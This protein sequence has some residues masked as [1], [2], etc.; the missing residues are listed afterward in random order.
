MRGILGRKQ[1]IMLSRHT[2]AIGTVSRWNDSP[3]VVSDDNRQAVRLN[4]MNFIFLLTYI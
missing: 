3:L 1:L 4:S 2:V